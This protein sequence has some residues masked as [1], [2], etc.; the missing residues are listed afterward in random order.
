MSKDTD[1]GLAVL[2]AFIFGGLVGAAVAL[3]TAP[4]TGKE[5]REDLFRWTDGA[6]QRTRETMQHL[7]TD[8]GGRVR[9]FASETGER[10]K[11]LASDAG[12]KVRSAYDSAKGRLRREEPEQ[13]SLISDPD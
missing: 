7:A 5:T 4:K 11:D 12:E 3:L 6:A 1:S 8:T 13:E 9:T 2:G 10:V